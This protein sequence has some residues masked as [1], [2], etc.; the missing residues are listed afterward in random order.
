MPE[1]KPVATNEV[2]R[3]L[4]VEPTSVKSVDPTWLILY[5][6]PIINEPAGVVDSFDDNPFL[7]KS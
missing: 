4:F 7:K 1:P 3:L 2:P 5:V 6:V